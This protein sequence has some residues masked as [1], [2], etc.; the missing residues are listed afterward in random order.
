MARIGEERT[1]R[2]QG[3]LLTSLERGAAE[4]T[5]A[6][7][8]EKRPAYDLIDNNCQTFALALLDSVQIGKHRE[9]GSTFAIYERA[10]GKGKIKDLF[11]D[12]GASEQQLAE[13]EEGMP[14]PQR[15]D[16]VATAAHVMDENTTKLDSHHSL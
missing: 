3:T 8:R 13:A 16:T 1:K 12:E 11:V 10:T 15:H 5:I 6:K 7:M 2:E 14:K 9:F 4:M